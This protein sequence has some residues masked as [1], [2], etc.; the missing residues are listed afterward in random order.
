MD[1]Q[2]VIQ[3]PLS[4]ATADDFDQLL[5]IENKLDLVLRSKHQV[6]GHDIGSGE[7]NI[8]IHTNNPAEAFRISKDV[9]SEK[10]LEIVTIAFREL[11]GDKYS[12]L[13]PDKFNG[14]FTIKQV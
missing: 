13:W 12:V 11:N 7:M 1:Y 2:L 6:D 3:F 4:D 9:L 8:F 5:V 14:E 10:D